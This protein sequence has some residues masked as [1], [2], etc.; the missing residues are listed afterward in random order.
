MSFLA[1]VKNNLTKLP[2]SLGYPVSL[3]P[4]QYRP[5]IGRL[6]SERK[7]QISMVE[8]C[9]D[10]YL[11]KFI[12][13]RVKSV[14][15]YSKKNIPFYSRL[16]KELNVHPDRFKV[17]EDLANLPIINKSDLQK[18]DVAERSSLK[19]K[20]FSVNTGGSSGTPLDFHIQA[21]SIP[22]EWAH[23]HSIWA[24]VGFKQSDLRIVFAGR[25]DVVDLVEY[26]SARHQFNVNI[27][28]GWESIANKL[29]LLYT[30]HKP[31]FLH[32]YPSSIFD[33]VSW[34][35]DAEHPLLPILVLNIKGILL[36][37]EFPSPHARLRIE[38]ILRC[39]SVS[40]YGHTERCV[41][42]YEKD[43]KYNYIPF[44]TYGYTEAFLMGEVYNLIST[45]YYNYA[46]PMIRYNTED[47]IN[48]TESSGILREFQIT[49]GRAGEFIIDKAGNK[50]FLTALIFGRHHNI[51]D[52]TNHIQVEQTEIG[53]IKVYYVLR[54][55]AICDK[56]ELLFDLRN[57]DLNFV[58]EELKAP[59]TTSSGKV[60]LLIKR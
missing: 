51:F 59:I 20:S 53:T 33:F 52:V 13:S 40:W 10:E 1:Y 24:K 5:G 56:P 47:L 15:T 7:K 16:Y 31:N 54:K 32:G 37:S 4:Y 46:S 18:V 36:G 57:T 26:D 2:Y 60:P 19:V 55:G 44:Q 42:A 25:S 28:A 39:K 9:E 8:S 35:Y 41:L 12:F 49:K 23:M 30:K 45:S 58:F 22:H 43:I 48:P 50:V 6:Y 21:S 17:F 34:L 29:L 27:Y 3:I 14:S 11:K 38:N